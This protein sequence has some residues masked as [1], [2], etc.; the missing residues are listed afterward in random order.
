[1]DKL[2]FFWSIDIHQK[3]QQLILPILGTLPIK[4]THYQVIFT[5]KKH[6]DSF[7]NELVT[8]VIVVF[9]YLPPENPIGSW[10]TLGLIWIVTT[11][12]VGKLDISPNRTTVTA[13]SQ[14]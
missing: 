14:L 13:L 9:G 2:H 6:I 3:R 12:Q 10:I 7:Y 1:M 4:P 11:F 5:Q 8:N